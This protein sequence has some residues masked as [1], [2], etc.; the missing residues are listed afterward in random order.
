M[1]R[2]RKQKQIDKLKI[3][4]K[5]V[6][7]KQKDKTLAQCK[8]TTQRVVNKFVR[9]RDGQ[10]CL[11]CL[12]D[13]KQDASHYVN[14]GASGFLRY[15][16]LNI[17]NTCYSCNRFKGGNKVEYRIHLVEKIGEGKVKWLEANRNLIY[18]YTREELEAIRM[19]C[20]SGSYTEEVW[21]SI[22]I[23]F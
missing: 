12:R 6:S 19:A 22:M 4:V 5:K 20:K 8:K 3:R 17:H 2:A 15:H 7:S 9:E 18:K 16:P 14:Q 21:Q 10:P 1:D 23:Q 13:G 11:A